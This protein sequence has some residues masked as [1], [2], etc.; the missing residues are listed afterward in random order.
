MLMIVS[1]TSPCSCSLNHDCGLSRCT[2]KK[3]IILG[4]RGSV[5]LEDDITDFN[6]IMGDVSNPL[7]DEPRQPDTVLVHNGF[8][9]KW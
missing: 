3:R 6:I 8:K 1:E 2:E 9:R 4:F 5:T 7:K